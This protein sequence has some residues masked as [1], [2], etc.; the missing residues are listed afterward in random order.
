MQKIFLLPALFL[1]FSYSSHAQNFEVS[2]VEVP[3]TINV[4]N[5]KLSLNGAGI[6]SEFWIDLYVGSLYVPNKSSKAS[7]YITSD[8]N[9]SIHLNIVSKLVTSKKMVEAVEEGFDKAT[10]GNTGKLRKRID[11]LKAYFMDDPIVKGDHIELNY[12]A[13]KQSTEVKKNGKALGIIEGLDFKQGLIAIWLGDD[14]ADS[15]LKKAMLGQ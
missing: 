11:Q 15:K 1:L 13:S 4:N 3:A 9:I 2:G 8:N 5:E 7:D 10:D 6:R 12:H 14:P